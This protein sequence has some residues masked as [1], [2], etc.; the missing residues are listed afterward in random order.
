MMNNKKA[1]DIG[2]RDNRRKLV[3]LLWDSLSSVSST[4]KMKQFVQTAVKY[5]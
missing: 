5:S 2:S 4:K 3:S 1:D